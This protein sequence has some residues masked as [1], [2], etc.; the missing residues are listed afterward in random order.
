MFRLRRTLPAL[1]LL[2]FSIFAAA[3]D[4][5]IV[6]LPDTQFY[7]QSYPQI[8]NAQTQWIKDNATKLN[9]KLVLGEGDIVNGGGELGQWQ[10]ADAAM[11]T[12]NGVVPYM[13]AIGN[14]DYDHN[15][16][17]MRTA[18]TKNFN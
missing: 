2:T 8:F 15:D 1:F 7:S 5:T 11:R 4:F 13:S 18:S 12:L 17:P 6:A 9:I 10:N 16:P 3:Q 14:H